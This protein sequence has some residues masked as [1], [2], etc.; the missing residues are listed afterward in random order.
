M[1]DPTAKASSAARISWVLV[2]DFIRL[3][4]SYV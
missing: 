4:A 3:F 1:E 2:L